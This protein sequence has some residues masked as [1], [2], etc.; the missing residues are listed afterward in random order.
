L[1]TEN[2]LARFNSDGSIYRVG[3]L[4]NAFCGPEGNCRGLGISVERVQ[5]IGSMVG[6]AFGGREDS[7]HGH[8]DSFAALVGQG[9]VRIVNNRRESFTAHPPNDTRKIQYQAGS[10]A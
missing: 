7:E 2:S 6:G 4:S 9:T 10:K 1:E 3:Q 5:V 8:P